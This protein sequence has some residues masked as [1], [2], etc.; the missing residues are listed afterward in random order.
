MLCLYKKIFLQY[1]TAETNHRIDV[2]KKT[3][4]V[5]LRYKK[6]LLNK[7]TLYS[8]KPTGAIDGF[9]ITKATLLVGCSFL[10]IHPIKGIH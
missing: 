1:F 2:N 7:E 6:R 10:I 8:F 9:R 3:L 5:F 4:G